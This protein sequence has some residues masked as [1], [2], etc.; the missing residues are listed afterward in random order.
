[1]NN[2]LQYNFCTPFGLFVIDTSRDHIA[3]NLI[4]L[5]GPCTCPC[6]ILH[7]SSALSPVGNSLLGRRCTP[8]S[9]H[10][11]V[12]GIHPQDMHIYYYYSRCT[13]PYR[14]CICHHRK[15]AAAVPRFG[16]TTTPAFRSSTRLLA[17]RRP[18]RPA[19]GGRQASAVRRYG[20][21]R[22][23]SLTSAP[24]CLLPTPSR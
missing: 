2:D 15:G 4:G 6:C 10:L 14:C 24:M 22:R 17:S 21:Q 5:L 18:R 8:C 19:P 11:W 23:P 7:N 20:A 1:M 16:V 9:N 3:C 12:C 13:Y